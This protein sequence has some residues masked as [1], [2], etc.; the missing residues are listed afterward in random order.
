MILREL[1]REDFHVTGNID[2]EIT[3]ISYNSKDIK[4]A[5][6]FVAISGEKTDGH[7]FI[8]EAIKKR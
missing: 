3:H 2:K 6:L 7:L 8:E 1:L 5:S 4:E